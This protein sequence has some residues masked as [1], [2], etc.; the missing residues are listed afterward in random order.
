[1]RP[2]I[3]AWLLSVLGIFFAARGASA[4]PSSST[5]EIRLL[6]VD[7]EGNAVRYSEQWSE[8]AD[9]TWHAFIATDKE[10]SPLASIGIEG[11]TMTVDDPTGYFAAFK[12]MSPEDLH[13]IESAIVLGK[14]LEAPTKKRKIRHVKSETQCGSIEIESNSGW[15]RVAEVGVLS[16]QFE[17]VCPPLRL[18]GLEHDGSNA[19]FVRVKYLLGTKPEGDSSTI[20]EDYDELH[21]L[22]SA[23]VAAAELALLGERARTKR[24]LDE[25][26]PMLEK[27]IRL[28]PELMPARTS[29]VRAYAQARRDWVSLEALLDTPVAQRKTVIGAPPSDELLASLWPGVE[30]RE[31]PWAWEGRGEPSLHGSF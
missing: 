18:E 15:L 7:A 23:R 14:K 8:N 5:S 28:A 6:G 24:K 3:L 29:I 11:T 30:D 9:L 21:V 13:L 26:I 16:Y 22:G 1:M 19:V 12:K 10:G 4:C 27:A 2:S 20:Y 25:A 17:G 31:E